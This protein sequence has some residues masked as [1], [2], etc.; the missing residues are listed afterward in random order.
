MKKAIWGTGLY[1]S[2]FAYIVKKEEIDFFIDNDKKKN[3]QYF[4]GK[5]VLSP[6]E[7]KNW[8]ELYIYIPFNFYDEITKQIRIYGLEEKKHYKKYYDINTINAKDFEYDYVQALE[9]LQMQ[10]K[11]KLLS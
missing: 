8:N 2:E 3:G 10:E 6:D 7:I 4:L 9:K 1:A 11:K 5:K